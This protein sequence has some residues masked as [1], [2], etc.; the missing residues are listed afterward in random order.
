MLRRIAAQEGT[1]DGEQVLLEGMLLHHAS[2]TGLTWRERRIRPLLHPGDRLVID[3]FDRLC[4]GE[5]WL[6]LG[7]LFFQFMDRPQEMNPTALMQALVDVV[8]RVK[9]TAEDSAKVFP[10][11]LV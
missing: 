10:E 6:I 4:P 2:A 5:Q 8:A 1:T 7:I 3:G 9:I 11:Q